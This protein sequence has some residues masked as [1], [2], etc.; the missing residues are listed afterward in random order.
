MDSPSNLWTTICNQFQTFLTKL[1]SVL[2]L[3]VDIDS[4]V[5][6]VMLRYGLIGLWLEEKA[7]RSAL[8][9]FN[10]IDVVDLTLAILTS[11]VKLMYSN[12]FITAHTFNVREYGDAPWSTFERLRFKT[13]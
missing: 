9:G 5:H 1:P 13:Y 6:L 3:K 11:E 2:P 10:S 8:V 12:R 4:P 7:S